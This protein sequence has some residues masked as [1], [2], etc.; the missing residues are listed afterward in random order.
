MFEKSKSL[1]VVSLWMCCFMLGESVFTSAGA[2]D[3]RHCYKK[4]WGSDQNGTRCGYIQGPTQ[5]EDMGIR[6]MK[7]S[8]GECKDYGAGDVSAASQ[9]GYRPSVSIE[10]KPDCHV[11]K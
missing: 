9:R 10:S 7:Q 11:Q 4:G 2:W 8:E 1:A 3:Y 6:W 5:A